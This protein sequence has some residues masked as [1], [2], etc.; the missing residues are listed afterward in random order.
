[1]DAGFVRRPQSDDNDTRRK[2]AMALLGR[3]LFMPIEQ[4]VEMLKNFS[5]DANFGTK[6]LIQMSDLDLRRSQ[7]PAPAASSTPETP[8]ACT[9]RASCSSSACR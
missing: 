8:S 3:L 6:G 7:H 9:C 1:M 4:E 5:H 2:A